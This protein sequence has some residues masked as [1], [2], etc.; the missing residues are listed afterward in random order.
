MP[1]GQSEKNTKTDQKINLEPIPHEMLMAE[2]NYI[3]TSTNQSS[4]DRARM[5]NYYLVTIGAVIA[6]ASSAK[7]DGSSSLLN[8]AVGA[9]LF[10][11][12]LMGLSTVLTLI[13]L[14]AGWISGAKAMNKIKQYYI[15]TFKNIDW[16]KAFDWKPDNMPTP[17]K[18]NS[19]A[20][21]TAAFTILVD[22]VIMMLAV[23]Y[24]SV[25]IENRTVDAPIFEM[26]F[27]F[28]VIFAGAQFAVYW[29]QLS[30]FRK[31]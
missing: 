14:R 18:W 8:M 1:D 16:D 27:R 19:V 28:G 6:A 17:G 2:F 21:W 25:G 24:F 13:R 29:C 20:F 15:D 12:A 7:L 31:A 5:S 30:P 22:S 23:I 11:I 10:L 9:G 4:E 26:A 3:A